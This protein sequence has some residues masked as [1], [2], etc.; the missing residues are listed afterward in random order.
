MFKK[1]K[2]DKATNHWLCR[3]CLMPMG[4]TKGLF[5]PG[6]CLFQRVIFYH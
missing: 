5:A 4:G 1:K 2:K 3:H 6:G